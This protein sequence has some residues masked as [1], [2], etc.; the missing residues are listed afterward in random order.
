MTLFERTLGLCA[1]V[2]LSVL[3]GCDR[4]PVPPTAA[5]AGT[6]SAQRQSMQHIEI[7]VSSIGEVRVDGVL[8]P[9]DQLDARFAKLA[10]E[11]GT[12]WYYRDRATEEP[13]PNAM[14]VLELVVKHRVPISMSSKPDFSDYIDETGESRPR[15]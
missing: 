6:Q 13:H 14:R 4:E 11:A 7:Q 1:V 15:K 9:I 12:V 2:V 5:S 8:T 10:G 3:G